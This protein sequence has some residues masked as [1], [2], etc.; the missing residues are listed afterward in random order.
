MGKRGPLCNQRQCCNTFVEQLKKA[1]GD[2]EMLYL[3]ARGIKG[4]SHMLMQ[5][6]NSNQ[7]ADLL[8]AWIDGHVEKKKGRTP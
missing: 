8:I 7:L 4:N 6:K 1:G 2:A 3:P 5:D